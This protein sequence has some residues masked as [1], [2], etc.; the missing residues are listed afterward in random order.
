VSVCIPSS[1]WPL[2]ALPGISVRLHPYLP[3]TTVCSPWQP[4]QLF[5]CTW[6]ICTINT[7]QLL[8]ACALTSVLSVCSPQHSSSN[9]GLQPAAH[10]Q[11]TLSC[12]HW[13]LTTRLKGCG[14]L[15]VTS[16][17]AVTSMLYSPSLGVSI[18]TC[19]G[20]TMAL[21]WAYPRAS[22]FCSQRS[23]P[24]DFTMPCQSCL[25]AVYAAEDTP[26]PL[27]APLFNFIPVRWQIPVQLSQALL[28]G[29]ELPGL[30]FKRCSKLARCPSLFW[31]L[32]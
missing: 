8:L 11:W 14:P 26:V 15:S 12:A 17:L 32:C 20:Q 3:L 28:T 1:R 4:L 31:R 21:L 19:A 16:D 9:H 24:F 13:A 23:S 7:L 10:Q 22:C 5:A 27:N 18:T 30:M 2:F 29:D 25:C 6:T